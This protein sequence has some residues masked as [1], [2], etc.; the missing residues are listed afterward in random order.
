MVAF[1]GVIE[2]WEASGVL[3]PVEFSTVDYET[4]DCGAVAAYPFRCGVDDY[5]G[6]MVDWAAEIASCAKGVVDYNRNAVPMCHLDNL[7]E[8]WY[9]VS[10]IANALQIDSLGLVINQFL[11]VLSVIAFDEFS[12]DAQAGEG[13]F[14]LVVGAAVEIGGRNDVVTCVGEGGDGH[15]LGGLARCGCYGGDAAFKGCNA[16]FENVDC[17]LEGGRDVSENAGEGLVQGKELWWG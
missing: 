7:L 14:E 8:I 4:A 1:A 6:A 17:G 16:F 9:I 3:A 2:L 13:D 11:E 15:E 10:R 12:R 5:V